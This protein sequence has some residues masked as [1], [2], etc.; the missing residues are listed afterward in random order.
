MLDYSTNLNL[1]QKVMDFMYK[2]D[3]LDAPV[4]VVGETQIIGSDSPLDSIVLVVFLTGIEDE[5][6]QA[7]GKKVRLVLDSIH[8]FN[9]A[10]DRHKFDPYHPT[11]HADTLV[12]Y[13]LTL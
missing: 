13:L 5:L 4:E 2:D 9:V 7:I 8:D 1:M 10:D 12:R 11:L 6:E 3:L